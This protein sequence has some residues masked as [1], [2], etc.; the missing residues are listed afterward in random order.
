MILA[1][2]PGPVKRFMAWLLAGLAV[3]WATWAAG[4]RDAR[5]KAALDAARGHIKTTERMHNAADDLPDDDDALREWLRKRSQ[6]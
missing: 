5:Q 1:I 2:I 4:K 6:R 3:L